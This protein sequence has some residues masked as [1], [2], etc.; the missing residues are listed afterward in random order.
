MSSNEPRQDGASSTETPPALVRTRLASSREMVLGAILVGVISVGFFGLLVN[1]SMLW[2]QDQGS[3]AA[4]ILQMVHHHDLLRPYNSSATQIYQDA[5]FTFY[6]IVCAFIYKIVGG[7]VLGLMNLLSALFGALGLVGVITAIRRAHGIPWYVSLLLFLSMPVVVLTFSYGNETAL[8]FGLFGLALGAASFGGKVAK[9]VSPVL[10]VLACFAR[11]DMVLICPYWLG[12]TLLYGIGVRSKRE[13]LNSLVRIGLVFGVAT[14]IYGAVVFRGQVP[15]SLGFGLGHTGWMLWVGNVTFPFC[16]SLVVVGGVGA[17]FFLI[18]RPKEGLLQLLLLI[19]LI[20]YFN[21]LYSPK[22]LIVMSIFYVVPTAWLLLST[23]IWFRSLIVASIAFWW[24][25]A[26]SNFG[27]F[28]PSKGPEWYLPT[29][30]NAIPTGSYL[31]FYNHVRK[32]FYHERYVAELDAVE[33]AVDH[34]CSNS[35][36]EPQMLWGNFNMH[37][38]YYVVAK[39]NRI[40][41]YRTC[42]DWDPEIP[43]PKNSQTHIYMIQ[44]SYLWMKVFPPEAKSELDLWINDGRVREVIG[45]GGPFPTLIEVGPLVPANTNIDLGKRIRF[46]EEYYLG[47]LSSPRTEMTESFATLNWIPRREFAGD[48]SSTVYADNEFVALAK[49]E[50]TG[51]VFGLHFPKAYLRYTNEDT[52]YIPQ[53]R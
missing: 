25:F 33:K 35:A 28:G 5:F 24:I 18:K 34:L 51:K 16:P 7:N 47:S 48:L 8:S 4:K 52:R 11:A 40:E 31:S 14:V 30:D 44:L 53:T 29:A 1:R 32:G 9:F 20:V 2:E 41:E 19:P 12:W 45:D 3:K 26:V 39:Q 21:N 15:R 23:P 22:Y 38:L 36:H 46:A 50:V 42:F 37:L 13:L 27:F 17:L 6:Y 49:G 43:M 10:M